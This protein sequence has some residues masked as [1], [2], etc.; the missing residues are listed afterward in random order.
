MDRGMLIRELASKLGVTEDTVI[1]WELR[2][3][4]PR[5]K[6]IEKLNAFLKLS[7][8]KVR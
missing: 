8:K 4:K 3:I 7:Y 6:S 2:N 5:G 1:N